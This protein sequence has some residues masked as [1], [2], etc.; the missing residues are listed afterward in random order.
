MIFTDD[1]FSYLE[2]IS[3][4]QKNSSLSLTTSVIMNKLC[5]PTGTMFSYLQ[6]RGMDSGGVINRFALRIDS[7]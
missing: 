2:E 5:N 1:D 3:D 6:M 7:N 4:N